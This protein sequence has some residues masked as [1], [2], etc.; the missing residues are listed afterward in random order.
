[1]TLGKIRRDNDGEAVK[2]RS[3]SKMNNNIILA[4]GKDKMFTVDTTISLLLIFL[5]PKCFFFT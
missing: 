4:Q 2:A 3:S 1:M 5:V